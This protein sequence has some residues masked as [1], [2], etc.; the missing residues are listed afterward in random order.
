MSGNSL[1]IAIVGYG[2]MGKTIERLAEQRGHD[3][4]A[5]I[6]SQNTDDLLKLNS[7][8]CDV[9]IEF[10]SPESVL[11]NLNLLSKAG[12]NTVCGTT[13]W[14]D[15]YQ[16]ICTQ[17]ADTEAGFLYA[18]NFSIGVNIFFKVNKYLAQLLGS[19]TEYNISM[20]EEHHIH[21]KDA[22]SGTAVTLVEDILQA[23]NHKTKWSL[24]KS[25][26]NSINIEAIR[27][28]DIKGTH[29]VNYDSEID[30]L[31]ISH[32]AHTR[33]GFA[34]GALLAAEFLA[35]KSGTFTMEDVLESK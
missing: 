20:R 14:L 22:P 17:F 11:S 13:A 12:I 10:S 29:I 31:S 33:E 15:H 6:G 18:S 30:S 2:K 32:T 24:D 27:K 25:E 7:N 19:R 5:K 4:I 3:I 9:A 34:L 8:N 1:R 16:R 35:H 28:G 21:K 26:E 23:S